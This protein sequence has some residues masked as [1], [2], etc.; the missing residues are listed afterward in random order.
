[1][2]SF[3][4]LITEQERKPEMMTSLSSNGAVIISGIDF[5]EPKSTQKPT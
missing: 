2:Q 5:I 3:A 1:M 4:Q